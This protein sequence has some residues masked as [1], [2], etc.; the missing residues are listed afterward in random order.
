MA[1]HWWCFWVGIAMV[2]YD[3]LGHATSLAARLSGTTGAQLWHT[4]STSIWPSLAN[5]VAYDAYGTGFF[6]IALTLTILG[7]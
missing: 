4:S 1:R 2:S 5:S 7:R 3:M 6:A